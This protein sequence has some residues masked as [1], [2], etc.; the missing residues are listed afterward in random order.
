MAKRKKKIE[1]PKV[2]CSLCGQQTDYYSTAHRNKPYVDD[3]CYPRLCFCCYWVPKEEEQI[4]DPKDGHIVEVI[5]Y[6]YSHKHLHTP[7]ELVATSI[8]ED[9]K[10]A[11][12]CVKAV[13]EAIKS[14]GLDGRSKGKPKKRPENP[15]YEFA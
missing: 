9:L 3:R 6:P 2:A 7:E 10:Q 4:Y 11:K 14:A 15:D 12:I 1:E 8:A 13:K 5:E